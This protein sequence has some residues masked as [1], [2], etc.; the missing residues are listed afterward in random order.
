[1]VPPTPALRLRVS[2]EASCTVLHLV[3]ELDIATG[4]LLRARLQD[5]LEPRREPPVG[6]L[7][8]DVAGLQ[9]VD[10]A[11]LG[12][13]LQAERV[14]VARGGSLSLRSPSAMVRRIVAVLGLET[15]LPPER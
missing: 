7:V 4:P 2:H 6:R 3:G 5:L 1:M 13:L 15:R 14:L 11:G 10:V 9:F 8:V 12:V